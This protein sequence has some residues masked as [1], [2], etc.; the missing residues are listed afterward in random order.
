MGDQEYAGVPLVRKKP[1][2]VDEQFF[3][4]RRTLPRIA[5][6]ARPVDY[7][8]DGRDESSNSKRRSPK[9]YQTI[10]LCLVSTSEGLLR[11]IGVTGSGECG[12]E[13]L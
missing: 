4:R 7:A 9:Q 5:C 3:L 11:L 6:A 10:I 13:F 2:C 8:E 1:N 12:R